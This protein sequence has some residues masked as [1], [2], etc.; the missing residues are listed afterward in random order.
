M[1]ERVRARYASFRELLTQNNDCLELMAGLQQDLQYVPPRREVVSA[2]LAQIFD[3]AGR[4]AGALEQLSAGHYPELHAAVAGQRDEVERYI[5][6]LNEQNPPR[7]AARLSE[8][9]VRDA[10]EVGGKAAALAEIR[11][12]VRLPAPDGFVLTTEA[13]R[14][15][16]GIPL[17][18]EVR[19]ALEDVD[20]NDAAALHEI[21]GRLTAMTLAQPLPRPLEVAIMERARLLAESGRGLAV[22]SSAVAEGGERT[23]AG[24]FLTLLNVP[25]ARAVE[26]Y[27]EVVAARFSEQALFYRLSGGL[28]EVADPMAV[29]VLPMI[30][31]RAAGVMY[32]RDPGEPKSRNVW[33]TATRGLGLEMAS[34]RTP[35]DLFVVSRSTPHRVVESHIVAKDEELVMA[36]GG[37][38][39]RRLVDAAAARGATLGWRELE[40][41]AAFGLKLEEYFH[42]PQD[43]EWAIDEDGQPWILQSRALALVA[44]VRSARAKKRAEAVLAGGRAVFPGRVSGPAYLAETLPAILAAPA[45]AV[46]FIRRPS[47]EI[48]RI[49]PRIAGLVAEWGNVT[50][51]AAALLREFKVPSVFL[52]PGAFDHLQHGEPVSLD[53]VQRE[54]ARGALWPPRRAEAGP[55]AQRRERRGD[56]IAERVLRL[57]LLDPNDDDF[58]PSACR[59]THDVL[60][61]CHEKAIDA[62][63]TINDVALESGGGFARRLATRVPVNICVLDLGG[64][65]DAGAPGAAEVTPEQVVSRPFQAFWKGVTHP[66]VSWT[67]DMPASFSDL[68]SV[69]S[70]S[71]TPQQGGNIRALGEKSYLLV[72]D[73]YMNLNSRLAYHYSLVDASLSDSP[74]KNYIAMR[75]E[76]GGATRD[77]RSLRACFIESCLA[78]YGYLVDRRG[79]LVN[80]WYKKAPAADTASRLDILGRLL[81]CS[82]QLDMFMTSREVMEWYAQQFVAENYTFQARQ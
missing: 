52:M 8:V 80:A 17:W 24:Q 38:V 78:H 41:L 72:G 7:L 12:R 5:A 57:N 66:G 74:S 55:T 79:D 19:D 64:G 20:V 76:G 43:V 26:A 68:V 33:I 60:R 69:M 6:L 14:Q 15:F 77:R 51:H 54:V 53:A 30:R 4:M 27:R 23:C 46:V 49:F 65:I 2:R 10:A 1:V 70:R 71:F 36:A 39:A 82:S 18:T 44:P 37:G 81:A 28:I 32:T 58:R 34:G 11:N 3:K 45:G 40:T 67:R 29:L 61:F 62:M 35:A 63:F 16:C 42:A 21:S 9:G 22:R 75:F 13:Y 56:P 31:A 73:E 59:S 47:P 25:P 50:G 48:V